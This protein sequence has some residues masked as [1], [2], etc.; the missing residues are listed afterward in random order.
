MLTMNTATVIS[1]SKDTIEIEAPAKCDYFIDMFSM[2]PRSDAPFYYEKREGDFVARVRVSPAFRSTYDAG[3]IFVYDKGDRW[4]KFEFELT[5]LGSPS[6][7]SVVTD[8]VSDD[9]NGVPL[10]GL[11]AVWLQVARRGDN[12]CLHYSED[13]KKWN[14]VRY[15]HLKMKASVR[16]GLEAQS[17]VGKGCAVEF[18]RYSIGDN[19]IKDM[20]KGR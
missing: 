19:K 7:V 10:D 15:F 17:P 16:V 12:W 2:K 13:G 3:G 14:M 5:D 18:F 20:R 4:I 8:K 1:E 9:C 6:I 11:K